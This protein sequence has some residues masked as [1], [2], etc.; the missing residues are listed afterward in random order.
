MASIEMVL[1]QKD[2]HNRN[3]SS[4]QGDLFS[5]S[6]DEG[7]VA[8]QYAKDVPIWGLKNQLAHEF[9]VL[10]LYFSGHPIDPYREEVRQLRGNKIAKLKPST[11]KV[12]VKLVGLIGKQKRMTTKSGRL[13]MLVELIDDTGEL[14]IACFDDKMQELQLALT[15][16]EVVVIEGYVQEGKNGMRFSPSRI[17]GLEQYRQMESPTLHI[18]VQKKEASETTALELGTILR[19][20]KRGSSEVIVWYQT[21]E[22]RVA[23]GL[24]D[25][26][27]IV[28]S[29]TL[30]STLGKVK[31]VAKITTKYG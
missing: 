7:E 14:E 15:S 23:L 27:S 13:F 22:F 11:R 9:Q 3:E 1:S 12:L 6:Q 24:D 25:G 5:L 8:C 10:G 17:I 31:G 18:E 16:H 21:E 20:Q 26:V 30:L 2:Q 28:V 19:N 4:G 29:E